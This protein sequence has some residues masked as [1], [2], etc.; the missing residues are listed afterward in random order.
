[1]TKKIVTQCSVEGCL[2]ETHAKGKCKSH[3]RNDW[4]AQQYR[5]KCIATD[6]TRRIFTRQL[7]SMHYSLWQR[8]GDENIRMHS[9]RSDTPALRFWRK[10]A[11][12]ANPNKCWEWRHGKVGG[13][14]V[15]TLHGA[16]Y[17]AHRYAWFL[18]YGKHSEMLIRHKCDNRA[19][20]NPAHLEEGT[21]QD[22]MT[23]LVLR[24]TPGQR[25][26]LTI[27]LYREIKCLL[28]MYSIAHVARQVG[29]GVWII[30]QIKLNTHW[31]NRIY[32]GNST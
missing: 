19:C 20:V 12:T 1:M 10:V 7:C 29:K 14:G 23:D 15:F 4:Y 13:Y 16:T 18:T 24:G 26:P 17:K 22:N 3:Y 8:Y 21:N 2:K 25:K 5:G 9:A 28:K 32:D 11:I 27:E 6:C 31:T 30:R